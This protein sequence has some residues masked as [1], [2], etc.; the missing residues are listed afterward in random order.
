MRAQSIGV[1]VKLTA[2]LS[3]TV[4]PTTNPK[5]L[6]KRPTCPDMNAIGAKITASDSV[7]ASTA[8][9]ISFVATLAA[10]HG[11]RP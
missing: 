2:M 9:A 4:N 10:S 6:K 11:V 7:V 8:S 1:S 3:S 5:L